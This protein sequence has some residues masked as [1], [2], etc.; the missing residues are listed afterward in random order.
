MS[1]TR[2]V[3]KE[4]QKTKDFL[5]PNRIAIIANNVDHGSSEKNSQNASRSDSPMSTGSEREALMKFT[6]ASSQS[7]GI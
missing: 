1:N 5:W 6:N 7:I 4:I 3:G 2:P